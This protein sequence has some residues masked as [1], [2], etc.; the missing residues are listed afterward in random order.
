MD[1][2]QIRKAVSESLLRVAFPDARQQAVLERIR[3]GKPMKKKRISVAL[4]C[5]AILTLALAGAALAAALGVFGQLATDEL[6]AQ[7]MEKLDENADLLN[8]HVELEAQTE[9]RPAEAETVYQTILNH[10]YGR[11]FALTLN[12][13]YYD[14]SKLYYT[15][16]LKADPTQ[17]WQGE[18]LPTGFDTWDIENVGQRYEDVWA[19]ED[20]ELDQ[21]IRNGLNGHENGWFAYET[22]GLGDGADTADGTYLQIINS[23]EQWLDECTVQGYQEVELPEEM[24]GSEELD[25]VLTVM[26][27]ASVYHQDESG[28]R[29]AHIASAENR[30]ILHIP[31]TVRMNGSTEALSGSAAYKDYTAEATLNV[32]DVDINGKVTLHCPTA[33]TEHVIDLI[34]NERDGDMILDYRLSVNGKEYTNQEGSLHTPESGVLEITVRFDRVEEGSKLLLIP[35]YLHAGVCTEEAIPIR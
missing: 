21:A 11:S 23:S 3:G 8:R 32:S 7:R 9:A 25:I 12:Q 18:G 26:Y 2:N 14:G 35:Q 28:V 19:N 16:T 15:Y 1:E 20:Q 33:W 29:W 30:G 22:W 24:I 31:F 4:V 10:Q 13:T 34:E 27:G 17:T 5:A 6:T